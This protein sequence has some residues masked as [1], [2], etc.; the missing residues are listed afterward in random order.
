MMVY[1]LATL[2]NSGGRRVA[3]KPGKHKTADAAH[4]LQTEIRKGMPC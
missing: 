3:V 2:G 4:L 1:K